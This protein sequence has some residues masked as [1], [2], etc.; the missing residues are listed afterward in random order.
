MVRLGLIKLKEG[1]TG[2]RYG[3]NPHELRD[4]FRTRFHLSRRDLKAAEF[5]MGHIV[6]PLEYNKAFR[7]EY[8]AI[9]E[10]REASPW[11][12]ILSEDP[13]HI[14]ISKIE[15]KVDQLVKAKLPGYAEILKRL[16]VLEKQRN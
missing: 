11:L 10:Y 8:Y 15:S 14:H 9:T 4:L 2:N 12:N 13:E 6:D 3:K 1:D 16:E 5:F 7:E